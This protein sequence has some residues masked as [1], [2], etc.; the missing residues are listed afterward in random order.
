[1]SNY[2]ILVVEDDD[3]IRTGMT[4]VLKKFFGPEVVAAATGP[5]GH[6]AAL[7]NEFDLII[8]D[9]MLPGMDGIEILKSLQVERPGVP[10][11]MLT[12]KG[13]EKDRVAGLNIGAD[14]YV[15]K[16]FSVKELLA[17]IEAVLRRSPGRIVLCD[18]I[19]IPGGVA[20]MNARHLVFDNEIL[21]VPLTAREF[22]LLRYFGS[23]PGR[24]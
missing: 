21:P 9:W 13:A 23:H 5:E 20:D 1:M 19:K 8:L 7:E 14:D 2:R 3:A 6:K 24:V 16:P 15:V 18:N 17:R 22:D 12:A 11:I 4:D 10:V